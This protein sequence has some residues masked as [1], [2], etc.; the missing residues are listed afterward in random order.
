MLN[1]KYV[2]L[3][4]SN[5]NGPKSVPVRE[6]FLEDGNPTNNHY[7]NAADQS[8]EEQALNQVHAPDHQPKDHCCDPSGRLSQ[9]SRDNAMEVNVRRSVSSAGT[10]RNLYKGIVVV[11]S[12][13]TGGSRRLSGIRQLPDAPLR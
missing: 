8:C 10:S 12:E 11:K 2:F 7:K 3:R 4:H 6:A 13:R 1:L 5:C 9:P